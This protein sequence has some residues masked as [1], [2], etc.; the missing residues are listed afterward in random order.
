MNIV[1][2]FE[3]FI[4]NMLCILDILAIERCPIAE[5][6]F[7]GHSRSSKVSSIGTVC[8]YLLPPG[9]AL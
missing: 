9:Y 1:L 2:A 6:T 8:L 7:Q 4:G 3:Y 5:M